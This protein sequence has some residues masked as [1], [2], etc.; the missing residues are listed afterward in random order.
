NLS[1]ASSYGAIYSFHEA[2]RDAGS[3]QRSRTITQEI[4]RDPAIA[5]RLG[6]A[7]EAELFFLHRVRLV[8]DAPVAVDWLWSPAAIAGPLLSVDF[9]N[10]AFYRELLE[11]TGITVAGG[12]EFIQAL[13]ADAETAALLGCSPGTALLDIDRMACHDGTPI[14]V[15]RTLAIGDRLRLSRPFGEGLPEGTCGERG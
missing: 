13:A 6:L 1:G 2:A 7:A 5:A 11:R 8:D 4:T 12:R 9:E 14:E 3:S 15:R 10:T